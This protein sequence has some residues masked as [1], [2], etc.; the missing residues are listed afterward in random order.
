M[1]GVRNIVMFFK[2]IGIR[3]RVDPYGV[4]LYDEMTIFV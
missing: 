1:E 3:N 4:K 2:W